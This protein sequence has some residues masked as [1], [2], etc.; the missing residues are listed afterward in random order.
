[1]LSVADRAAFVDNLIC[2]CRRYETKVSTRK[3]KRH[4]SINIEVEET[5]SEDTESSA[6]EALNLEREEP[7]S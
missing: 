3:R 5:K 7:D 6:E 2:L 4:S 1:M